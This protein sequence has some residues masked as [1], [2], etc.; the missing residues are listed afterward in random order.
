MYLGDCMERNELHCPACKSKWVRFHGSK[1]EKTGTVLV[2]FEC[3]DCNYKFSLEFLNNA[4]S[5][6]TQFPMQINIF[7]WR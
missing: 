6:R 5:K 2:L 7:S 1:E 4:R 3:T